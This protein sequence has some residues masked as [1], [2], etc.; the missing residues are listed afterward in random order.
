MNLM[1]MFSN[2]T[3]RVQLSLILSEKIVQQY[4]MCF[5]QATFLTL[6]EE[7]NYLGSVSYPIMYYFITTYILCPFLHIK[8]L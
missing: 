7:N 4:H 8:D 3:G 1:F 6:V 5:M 2:N